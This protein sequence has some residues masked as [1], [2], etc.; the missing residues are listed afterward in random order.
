[1]LNR[2]DES[3]HPFLVPDLSGKTFNFCPLCMMLA[4]GFPYMVFIMLPCGPSTSTC[5]VF[6]SWKGTVPYQMLFPCPSLW[7]CDFHLSI[8]VW[9]IT[10]I[11]L[12]ILYLPWVPGMNPTWTWCMIFFNVLLD[13]VCQYFV[14]DFSLYVHQQYW[15]IIFFL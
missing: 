11:D 12:W 4:V 10:F 3:R 13:A 14:E 15:P 7:T 6:W 5:W 8:C 9:C 1:M 2:S